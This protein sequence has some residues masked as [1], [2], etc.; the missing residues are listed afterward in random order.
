[1]N[2]SKR[3]FFIDGIIIILLLVITLNGITSF[4]TKN[5]YEVVN[6]YGDI[7]RIWGSGIYAHDSFFKAPIFIGSD[8]TILLVALPLLIATILRKNK[9][10]SLE[11]DVRSF[12]LLSLLLYYSASVCFGVTYNNLHLIYI[13]LF[14]LLFF[15]TISL[16]M[17]LYAVQIKNQ[18]A[19]TFCVSK[20]MRIFLVISGLSLF[21][22]WLPDIIVSIINKK[23]LNLI[24]VYTTEVTYIL[25]MG[26][27]SPLMFISLY[28][29]KRQNFIGYVILRMIF[30]T[31]ML[32]GIMLPIQTV[33]QIAAGITIPIPALITKV[34]IFVI[35]A[36]FS[37]VFNKRLMKVSIYMEV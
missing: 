7:I 31:C 21:V 4:N 32:V 36:F 29:S 15:R 3:V 17:K 18:N 19:C 22:A 20:G 35:L 27:I 12:T 8:F 23:S 26:I 30:F 9:T 2:S 1:M 5:A 16:L 34:F 11:Y 37:F 25:D 13:A 14:G 10:V 28:L 6:Q 24:E 33:F